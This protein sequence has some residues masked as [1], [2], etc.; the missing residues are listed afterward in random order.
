[1]SIVWNFVG[2]IGGVLVLYIYPAA[3]Y[4]KLRYVRYKQ[5]AKIGNITIRSQYTKDGIAKELI[6]WVILI[7]GF[8][9]LVVENYQAIHGAV[10]S[11]QGGEPSG[12]CFQ[13]ECTDVGEW[14]NTLWGNWL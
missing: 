5:R 12:L 4:L 14:N 1:M 7:A 13:L 2:S 10:I 8:L 6:A 11:G 3:C 9:L